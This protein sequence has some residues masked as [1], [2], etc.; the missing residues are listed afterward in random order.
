[1][2]VMVKSRAAVE[3]DTGI[4]R[5]AHWLGMVDGLAHQDA[6]ATADPLFKEAVMPE[7]WQRILSGL[8]AAW[9]PVKSR[10]LFHN[11]F[12]QSLPGMPAGDYL[13]L[14]FLSTFEN[15]PDAMET[16]TLIHREQD[17][18]QIAGFFVN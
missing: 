5:A 17:G 14:R 11:T 10:T 13:I 12:I 4:A 1:M 9:G 7:Q 6:W 16:L 3:D 8:R 15:K 2:Q 18:W